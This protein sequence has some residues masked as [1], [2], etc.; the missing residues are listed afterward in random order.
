[1]FT[2]PLYL[3]HMDGVGNLPGEEKSKGGRG[4]GEG[5]NLRG[6]SHSAGRHMVFIHF[7]GLKAEREALRRKRVL[8][9]SLV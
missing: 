2:F 1:M 3:K 9:K 5:S 7:C 8:Y 4:V 6:V